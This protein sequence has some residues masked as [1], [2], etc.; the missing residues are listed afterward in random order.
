M[1][2][3]VAKESWSRSALGGLDSSGARRAMTG[4]SFVDTNLEMQLAGVTIFWSV[5]NINIMR[6]SYVEGLGY[7]KSVQQYGARWFFT[8]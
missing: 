1:R 5:T 3:E 6:S 4:S 7:P 2:G 8:N